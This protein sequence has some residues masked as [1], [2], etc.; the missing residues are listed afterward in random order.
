MNELRAQYN[1]HITPSDKPKDIKMLS[2]DQLPADFKIPTTEEVLKKWGGTNRVSYKSNKNTFG[3]KG[4]KSIQ[5][6]DELIY[7]QAASWAMPLWYPEPNTEWIKSQSISNSSIDR[8][9][10][11]SWMYIDYNFLYHGAD[12][13]VGWCY[14]HVSG[15]FQRDTTTQHFWEVSG[16]H[17]FNYKKFDLEWDTWTYAN[18]QN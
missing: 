15:F 7:W 8:I 10:V 18:D 12:E 3:K 11:E 5:S 17:Y 9:S 6:D 4:N 2:K 16:Y 1:V 13:Q 14:A